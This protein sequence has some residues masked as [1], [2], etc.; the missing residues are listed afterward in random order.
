MYSMGNF[1]S[2]MT[3]RLDPET[4]DPPMAG[5]G[6]AWALSVSVRCRAGECA[7]VAAR[8]VPIA[9]YRNARGEMVVGRLRDLADGTVRLAAEWQSYYDA[10]LRFMEVSLNAPLRAV[11][12]AGVA[13]LNAPSSPAGASR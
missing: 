8:P 7:V 1:I 13:G 12:R 2:G 3:W 5:T 4:S 11:Y 6:E 10:R 9:N